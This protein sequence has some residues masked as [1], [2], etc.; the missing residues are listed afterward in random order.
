MFGGANESAVGELA[1]GEVFYRR[2]RECLNQNSPREE[3][4]FFVPRGAVS[5]AVGQKQK[6][7]LRLCREF[8]LRRVRVIE[9][10]SLKGYQIRLDQTL[11]DKNT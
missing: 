3:A 6:N 4:R 1:M 2:M 10:V 8:A 7:S 5:R 9:D 11:S